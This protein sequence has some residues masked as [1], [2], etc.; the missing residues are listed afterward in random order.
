MPLVVNGR[1]V[2][3]RVA[4]APWHGAWRC[5]DKPWLMGDTHASKHRREGRTDLL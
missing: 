5:W 1:R 2:L 4:E 3:G